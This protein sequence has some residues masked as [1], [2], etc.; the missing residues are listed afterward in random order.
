MDRLEIQHFIWYLTMNNKLHLAPIPSTVRNIIDVGCG[1]G[2]WVID[3]GEAYPNAKVTGTD[4]SP[5]QPKNVPENVSFIVDDFT[6]PW[7]FTH[8]FDYIHT[9]AIGVG[10]RDWRALIKQIWENL[11][12]GGWVEF[13]EWS[14][15]TASDDDTAKPDNALV[16]WLEIMAG[17]AKA[18]GIAVEG[19]KNVASFLRESG[20]DNVNETVTKWAI[21]PWPHGQREKRIGELFGRDMLLAVE[22]VSPRL[23]HS[24]LKWSEDE[25]RQFIEAAK[26][27]VMNPN[28]HIYMP[29]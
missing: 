24:Q 5:I 17:A 10:M 4:L 29:M 28:Q 20:F 8:K 1:T 16:R 13:Q 9:R 7:A 12:P 14:G 23:I 15:P 26:R 18:A 22:S 11:T 25:A 3:M 21:N 19:A 27:E 6:A 2:L